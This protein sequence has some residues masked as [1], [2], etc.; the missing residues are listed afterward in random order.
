MTS[1]PLV[2]RRKIVPVIPEGLPAIRLIGLKPTD[3]EK[4]MCAVEEQFKVIGVYRQLFTQH[5]DAISEQERRSIIRSISEMK[6]RFACRRYDNIPSWFDIIPQNIPPGVLQVFVPVRWWK[7][8]ATIS[9]D[10][11]YHV[12]VE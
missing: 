5:A 8:L 1:E 4:F 2:I 10:L 7:M 11:G 3:D 6:Q 9:S 12:P